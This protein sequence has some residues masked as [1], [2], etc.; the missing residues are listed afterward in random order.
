MYPNGN[1]GSLPSIIR[2]KI[3]PRSVHVPLPSHPT[4][5][6]NLISV[7]CVTSWRGPVHRGSWNHQWARALEEPTELE[8]PPAINWTEFGA[9]FNP[10]YLVI[11]VL[12]CCGIC[13]CFCCHLYHKMA[14]IYLFMLWWFLE[15]IWLNYFF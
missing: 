12:V 15:I 9:L 2:D 13:K 10:F 5:Q 3:F 7:M 8:R 11:R 6:L 4:S 1:L 14:F